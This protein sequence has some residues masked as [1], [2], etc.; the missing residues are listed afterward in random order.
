[1]TSFRVDYKR[2]KSEYF[3]HHKLDKFTSGIY[4]GN[5]I[6]IIC[7]NHNG[8]VKYSKV[9]RM[10]YARAFAHIV[11]H[12]YMHAVI[13]RFINKHAS[14]MFDNYCYRHKTT[15]QRYRMW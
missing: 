7:I 9:Y 14:I 11:S 4:L 10:S 6:D 2:C 13:E 8:I 1:M 12:E 15:S 3:K 5:D